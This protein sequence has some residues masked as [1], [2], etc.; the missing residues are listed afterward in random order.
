MIVHDTYSQ[1]RS[2][3]N[4]A[5]R[6]S[7]QLIDSVTY[8]PSTWITTFDGYSYE[9]ISKGFDNA[10]GDNWAMSCS[11]LGTPGSDPTAQCDAECKVEDHCGGGGSCNVN[12]HICDCDT[13]YYPQC[14]SITSCTTC[15][16]V[17]EVDECS[18]FWKKNGTQRHGY[19]E[20]SD[21]DR[22]G[23][24]QY[25]LSYFA[26]SKSGGLSSISTFDVF[27]STSGTVTA[28]KL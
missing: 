26:G 21:V 14:T 19:F 17:P 15:L 18:V 5:L 16:R 22:D 24:T 11:V 9:L 28:F 12:T 25:R 23:S 8:D 10:L 27:Y 2:S 7:A 1:N 20:W 6:D 3:W 4:V 13:G